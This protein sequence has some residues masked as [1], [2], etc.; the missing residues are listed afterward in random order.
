MRKLKISVYCEDST[1]LHVD[2]AVLVICGYEYVYAHEYAM[3]L[4]CGAFK[5]M[6]EICV[7]SCP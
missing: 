5:H 6:Q 1:R 2:I 4:V 3:L 7:N